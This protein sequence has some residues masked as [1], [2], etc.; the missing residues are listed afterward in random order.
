MK[1]RVEVPRGS[2]ATAPDLY[3]GDL[4][5]RGLSLAEVHLEGRVVVAGDMA[6]TLS[7][8]HC[9]SYLRRVM[10]AIHRVSFDSAS[11]MPSAIAAP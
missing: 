9:D 7:R 1:C 6:A 2:R 10:R 5:A 11:A 3:Q 8:Q 4:A